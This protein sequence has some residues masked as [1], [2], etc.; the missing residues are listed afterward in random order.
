MDNQVLLV[1]AAVAM[2]AL[3]FL[4]ALRLLAIRV[5][6]MRQKR[7]PP[8]AIA[9]SLQVSNRLDDV[10]AADNFK[11]LFEVPVLFYALIATSLAVGQTSRWLVFGAW[12]FVLLR[13]GHSLIHCTYNKVMHRFAFFLSSFVVIVGLWFL[14][15]AALMG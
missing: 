1:G 15:L 3:S 2:A 11:N 14:L 13:Y 4:V 5:A 12:L 10:R 7:L 6:E 9:S 8:D